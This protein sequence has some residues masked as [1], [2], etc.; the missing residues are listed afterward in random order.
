MVELVQLVG[1]LQ[2]EQ[3]LGPPGPFQGLGDRRRVVLALRVAQRRQRP[4]V[5]LAV[6]DRRDD[7]LAGQPVMSDTTSV[8]L[9]FICSRAFCMCWV[10][11]AA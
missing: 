4:R 9:T 6:Q 5:A 2:R 11:L 1:L 10:W 3:V 8:S 7:P